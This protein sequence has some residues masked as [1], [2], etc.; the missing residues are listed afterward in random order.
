MALIAHYKLDGNAEDA[1]GDNH[2]TVVGEVNWVDGKIGQCGNF[3]GSTDYVANTSISDYLHNKKEASIAMWVKK[4]AIQYGFVQLSGYANSNGNLYPYQTETKVYLDIF[5]TNRLGPI[6]MNSSVLEW[7]HFVVTQKPGKWCLYQNGVLVHEAGANDYISTDYLNFEIGRNSGRRYANGKFDDVR[8]YDHALSKKEVKDLSLGLSN[9]FLLNTDVFDSENNATAG[10]GSGQFVIEEDYNC[11]DVTSTDVTIP[12]KMNLS[13][14]S[15]TFWAKSLVD[16]NSVGGGSFG[17]RIIQ[18]NGYYNNNSVGFG[19]QSGNFRYYVKGSTSSGWSTSGTSSR[20]NTIY[21]N[22]GWVFYSVVFESPN[23]ILFYMNKEL[24]FDITV[25]DGFT[26]FNGFVDFGTNMQSYVRDIRFHNSVLSQEKITEIY[27]EKANIDVDGNIKSNLNSAPRARYIRDWVNGSTVNGNNHWIEIQAYD[28]DG[29]NIALNKYAYTKEGLDSPLL[30]D[31]VT[32]TG[33]WSSL[34]NTDYMVVDL[35]KVEVLEAVRVWHY[36]G[37]GR[38][39]YDTK[40]EISEDGVNWTSIF[41]SAIDGT[42]PETSSGKLHQMKSPNKFHVSK[43]AKINCGNASEVGVARGL[44]A[45]YPLTSDTRDYAGTNDGV[46][47]G[48]TLTANGYDFDS[49]NDYLDLP[50]DLG[51]QNQVSAF[52]VFKATGVPGSNYHIIF[53]DSTLELSISTSDF[54]RSGVRTSTGRHVSN[55]GS[56]L[57]DGDFHHIGF[58]FDGLTKITYIEGVEVGSLETTGDLISSFSNRR[59]GRYGTSDSYYMNGLLKEARLYD[60]ALTPQEVALQAKLDLNQTKLEMTEDCIY[61]KGQI[62]E[63]VA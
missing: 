39:Y 3:N 56:G 57:L 51:Y 38:T 32:D 21:S 14:E 61:T 9:R 53:G 1:V 25:S 63:V 22:G 4:D 15:V 47:N 10:I 36:W 17:N 55:H 19:L 6:Y 50:N 12:K 2:G 62:K 5:R 41:D 26:G 11:V 37:D 49:I 45:Y 44:I 34:D 24:I 13:G 48:A 18:F 23:K 27:Q 33:Q 40:T 46:N 8:I 54:L 60:R 30:V 42:Y 35:G 31:G 52:A 59:I 58:T 29:N 20:A 43:E 28:F 16:R 7:H